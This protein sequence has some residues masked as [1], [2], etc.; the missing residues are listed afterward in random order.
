MMPRKSSPYRTSIHSL[1]NLRSFL[2][3]KEVKGQAIFPSFFPSTSTCFSNGSN[4]QEPYPCVGDDITCSLNPVTDFRQ[5][6][7]L[8]QPAS[9]LQALGLFSRYHRPLV[10]PRARPRRPRRGALPA[11]TRASKQFPAARSRSSSSP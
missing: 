6:R 1:Q 5:P 4:Q 10:A 7:P 8:D 11:T 2:G 9:G 3:E